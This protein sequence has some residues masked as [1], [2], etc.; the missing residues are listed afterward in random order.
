[1]TTSREEQIKAF[2][3]AAHWGSANRSSLAED[4]STRRY[5]RLE[6]D[7]HP[8]V[9]MDAPPAAEEPSCPPDADEAMRRTLG[10][11]ALAR[12]AGPDP[13]PFVAIADFLSEHGLSAPHILHADYEQGFLLLEDLG[14]AI[15]NR[16]ISGG[17]D[18]RPLYEA[19]IDALVALH[20]VEVPASLPLPGGE[21]VPLL[22]YDDVALA[23]EIKLLTEWYL[24][25]AADASTDAAVDEEFN[26][27]W[28][29]ALGK[30]T[31]PH[32]VLILRDYHADNLLWLPDRMG[33]ARVGILDFQDGLRG[34]RAYDLVSLLEDARRDVAPALAADMVE[35]YIADAKT[36]TPNFDEE[37]FRM[38][39]ALL[40][41]QRNTKILGIFARLWRRDGKPQYPS[42]MPRLWRYVESDLAHPAF[43]DLKAW[44]DQYIPQKWRGDFLAR[45]VE[46]EESQ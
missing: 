44:Y 32:E 42:Y 24:P 36:N 13:R 45:K 14:D 7:G 37:A 41:L 20:A 2:L 5:E 21:L 16:V 22:T 10:Y 28:R 31:K 8:A 1:M 38:G 40:G 15:F 12:L 19:A 26:A 46:A 9:L 30:L 18:E 35:R 27:L 29:D 33:A 25:A 34:H 23:E 3:E 11:N 43:A 6:R 4:A 17:A 39:Y